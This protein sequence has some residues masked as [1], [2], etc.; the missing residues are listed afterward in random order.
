MDEN[1]ALYL[2]QCMFCFRDTG[3]THHERQAFVSDK[4]RL[5]PSTTFTS[6]VSTGK[7]LLSDLLSP[8]LESGDKIIYSKAVQ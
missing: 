2:G 1:V 6:C 3:P 5:E 4:L 7:L 8:H